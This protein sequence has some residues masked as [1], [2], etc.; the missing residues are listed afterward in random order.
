MYEMS[1]NSKEQLKLDII[2]RLFNGKIT[3]LDAIKL[4]GK[5]S[6][7][8]YR[9]LSD[10]ERNGVLFIKHGNYKK[11][12]VNKT[13]SSEKI[14][15]L[16]ICKKKYL[17]LNRVH[18]YEKLQE[19]HQLKVS[20]GTF[21]NWCKKENILTKKT[22]RRTKKKRRNRRERMKQVGLML[23]M[24]GSP[25]RWFGRIKSCLVIA[26]DDANSEI[27]AG[28]FTPTETTFACMEVIKKV[29]NK[30]GA[31]KILYTDRAGIFGGGLNNPFAVKRQNFSQLEERLQTFGI[32]VVHAQS[33]EAK[34]RV[35][36]AFE[37]LQDRLVEE[38]RLANIFTYKDANEYLNN[39]FLPNI[40]NKKFTVTPT[41]SESAY[42]PVVEANLD[43]YFYMKETRIVKKDH[44][45]SYRG[46]IW[47]LKQTDE[48][49]AEQE[50][51]IR[52]YPNG[53][54]KIFYD[55]KEIFLKGV[56]LLAA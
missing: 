33:A 27:I 20:Y 4:L 2:A 47:D 29:L 34:G 28:G 55:N 16:D 22:N 12:P 54:T 15:I 3:V 48:Y 44:T 56:S 51:E 31:F 43:N 40:F 26:I 50:I 41:D 6:R 24:D 46:E 11:T 18:A 36:R 35:E 13:I 38:M 9:Y 42:I 1:L 19:H 21:Y 45:I 52:F 8:I 39:Y 53:T 37:T 14:R 23:Q 30:K 10:Y 49:L 32:N 7:T 17:T 5:S 25:H